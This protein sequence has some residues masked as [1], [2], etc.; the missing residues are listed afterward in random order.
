M[1]KY[2]QKALRELVRIGAAENVT[3][4]GFTEMRDFLRDLRYQ[5]RTFEGYP[6]RDVIRHHR[7]QYGPIYGVLNPWMT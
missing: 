3:N 1:R 2:T 4:Y 6:D 7:P 5:R